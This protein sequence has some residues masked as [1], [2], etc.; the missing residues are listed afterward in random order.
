[1]NSIAYGIVEDIFLSR[2]SLL[3]ARCSNLIAFF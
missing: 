3:V 2:C 1:M